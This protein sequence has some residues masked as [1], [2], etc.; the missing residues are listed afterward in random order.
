MIH[1]EICGAVISMRYAEDIISVWNRH[2]SD[3]AITGYIRDTLRRILN[4]PANTVM[5]YKPHNES[6]KDLSTTNRST[7]P[8]T[9]TSSANAS[10]TITPSTSTSSTSASTSAF[11][12]SS[13]S[14][15]VH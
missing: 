2:S 10:S 8:T 9:A 1:D 12:S 14:S 4:L 11:A 7:D 5:Q 3:T 6:L 15:Y 13:S